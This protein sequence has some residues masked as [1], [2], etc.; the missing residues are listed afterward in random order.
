[1]D[2]TTQN[3]T[4]LWQDGITNAI[5]TGTVGGRYIVE[6]TTEGCTSKDSV[7]VHYHPL[8]S[9]TISGYGKACQIQGM[10]GFIEI[11]GTN[12]PYSLTYTNGTTN[13]H[14]ITNQ[15]TEFV[16]DQEGQY[17][18]VN[19]TDGNGCEGIFSG[20]ANFELVGNGIEANFDYSPKNTYFDDAL[21]T[22]T[23]L[24]NHHTSAY[25]EFGDGNSYLGLGDIVKHE[26]QMSGHYPVTLTIEDEFGCTDMVEKLVPI[27]SYGFFLPNAF[28]PD[29]ASGDDINSFFGLI[30]NKLK[31]YSM[32][33]YDR[34]GNKIFET[35]D[36]T[37]PWDGRYKNKLL[38][39]GVY[40]YKVKII[41]L[42]D[43]AIKKV[44]TVTLIR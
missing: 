19:I 28:T 23:N 34:W 11:N 24:S 7:F 16:V 14:L 37:N 17:T 43:K 10:K 27:L 2:A 1:M 38:P 5:H 18:I 25:W 21:I 36:I 32:S 42:E 6:V 29:D 44:G 9:A 22:F 39:T 33:I 35:Y 12:P 4:Y 40:P 26:Y 20:T 15:S 30:S 41:D 13:Y 8:S 31:S 3:A